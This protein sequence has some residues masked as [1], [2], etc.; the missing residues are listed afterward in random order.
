MRG[1][2]PGDPFRGS[3]LPL[4][5][6]C[7]D[8]TSAELVRPAFLPDLLASALAVNLGDMMA[9]WTNFGRHDW[10]LRWQAIVRRPGRDRTEDVKAA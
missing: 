2:T 1:S 5:S 7:T 9:R 6:T 8:S 10:P 3:R 4:P